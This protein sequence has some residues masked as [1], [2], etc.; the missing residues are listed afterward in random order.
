M[1]GEIFCRGWFDGSL[2]R[3][4]PPCHSAP[5]PRSTSPASRP[6]QIDTELERLVQLSVL[7][8]DSSLMEWVQR[9]TQVLRKLQPKSS[10]L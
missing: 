7:S 1:E 3:R 4:A 2:E 6:R 9:R 10:D 8:M 5:V